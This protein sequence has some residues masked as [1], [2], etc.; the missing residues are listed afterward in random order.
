[1]SPWNDDISLDDIIIKGTTVSARYCGA[2]IIIGSNTVSLPVN[3]SWTADKHYVVKNVDYDMVVDEDSMT[4]LMMLKLSE[5]AL[6]GTHKVTF[7]DSDGTTILQQS[8]VTVE[9]SP[10]YSGSIPT[11]STEGYVL[12]GWKI[13]EN[14][15]DALYYGKDETLPVI[16]GDETYTAV[17]GRVISSATSASEVQVGDVLIEGASCSGKTV[18]GE[19]GG[20][21]GINAIAADGTLTDAQNKNHT[22]Y[23]KDGT[24]GNAWMVTG[25]G[26]WTVFYST[27]YIP[28]ISYTVTWQNEDSTILETD[29]NVEKDTTPSY[30]GATPT[31]ESADT[32]Y[33]YVLYWSDGENTYSPDELPKVTSDVTYTAVF[34]KALNLTS[35]SRW[36]IGDTVDFGDLTYVRNGVYFDSPALA[37]SGAYSVDHVEYFYQDYGS[38]YYELT[39]KSC[40][41]DNTVVLRTGTYSFMDWGDTDVAVVLYTGREGNGT[42]NNAYI[43]QVMGYTDVTWLDQKGNLLSKNEKAQIRKS[44][45]YDGPEFERT[46]ESEDPDSYEYMF[47]WTNGYSSFVDSDTIQVNPING[48]ASYQATF[49][50]SYKHTVQVGD[51]YFVGDVINCGEGVYLDGYSRYNPRGSSLSEGKLRIVSGENYDKNKLFVFLDPAEVSDTGGRWDIPT[52]REYSLIDV[53]GIRITGGDGTQENP[54]TSETV[55][56][57]TV[58]YQNEDGTFNFE[59]TLAAEGTTPSYDGEKP[60]KASD[61]NYIYKF[62][63]W[64][65]GTN[66]YTAGNLPEVSENVTYTAVFDEISIIHE[67]DVFV[68]NTEGTP[69]V[70]VTDHQTGAI[71]TAGTDYTL[72]IADGT[73]KITGIGTYTGEIQKPFAVLSR[74]MKASI[75]NRRKAGNNA[76]ATLSGEWYLPKNATNIKAGIAR[77]STDDTNAT[78]YDVYNNGVKKASALKTTSGKYSFSLLMNSTHAN[79]NLYAVTYV[80]YE[81]DGVPYVSISKMSESLA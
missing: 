51:V 71:L 54:F 49:R 5:T 55:P 74:E 23:N 21:Y 22:P 24:K 10:T 33:K 30:D 9:T 68:N 6:T 67:D 52:D 15:W 16:Y 12:T 79:Q 70:T 65:D 81:I 14:E 2:N 46:K 32:N 26:G 27:T 13:Q 3:G 28:D 29:A 48:K 36:Y 40:G 62:R 41:S 61:K 78:K 66:T 60:T 42:K 56:Y 47:R 7:L 11:S 31:N 34:K 58:T 69:E 80:T 1:M 76:K 64:T 45:T 35:D 63:G 59:Q 75:T 8:D 44:L 72:E 17:Y 18:I 53:F 4:E 73:V 19:Y 43:L 50:K 39:L 77:L 25:V 37:L 57:Y 38:S 20:V